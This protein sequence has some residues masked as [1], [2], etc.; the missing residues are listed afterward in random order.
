MLASVASMIDQFNMPNIHLLK[1]MG[2]EVH[3]ACNFKQ[4]NTCNAYRIQKLKKE[5]AKMDVHSHQWDCPRNISPLWN[6]CLAY[7][8]LLRMLDRHPFAWIHCHSPVG[9]AIARMAAYRKK[10]RV[11]YTAHGFHFYKGAPLRNWILYYPAEKLLSCWT[12]VLITVNQEDYWFAKRYLHA[13][14]VCHIPGVGIDT[15]KYKRL[16]N[17]IQPCRKDEEAFCENVQP[18]R[19]D[20]ESFCKK[21]KIPRDARILLSVGELSAR[22][23][24]RQAVQALA[25]LK[26]R[27][28]Y[29]LVC[30]QGSEKKKLQAYAKRLGVRRYLRMPGYQE[31]MLWIYQNADLFLFP[32]LQEGMPA[33]LM[34]AMAAGLPC[35]VSDIRGNREL[36]GSWP[37]ARPRAAGEVSA[38][39]CAGGIRYAPQS[40]PELTAALKIML[41]HA[42]FRNTCGS[43][44]QEKIKDYSIGRV[45]RRMEKIYR[46]MGSR[47]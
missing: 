29:Y 24:H 12:D 2:Y 7:Q 41:D 15:E 19:K 25:A 14:K 1:S 26:R 11:I 31:D 46:V 4:G 40:L 32:S 42:E 17:H 22:K 43:Y 21:Y 34:E 6:C 44:N 13:K 30:G 47:E 23:N 18:C 37:A 35:I 45:Q 33:A 36:I 28:V 39:C 16:C 27:D 20:R 10:V 38:G 8:Q 5:L 3:V 9:G